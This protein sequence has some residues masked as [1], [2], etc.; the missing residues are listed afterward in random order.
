MRKLVF[1]LLFPLF[2]LGQK[3]ITKTVESAKTFVLR[4]TLKDAPDST[5]VF[6]SRSGEAEIFSTSYTKNGAFTLFGSLPHN[7]IY[8]L[9]VVGNPNVAYLFIGN[10]NITVSGSA[11]SLESLQVV[12]SSSHLDYLVYKSRFNVL[13]NQ[14]NT[15]ARTIN[16]TPNGPQRDSLL[17]QF[18]SG[19]QQV[20]KQVIKFLKEKPA[21]PVTAFLLYVTSPIGGDATA[22]EKRYTLLLP[23]AKKGFYGAEIEKIILASKIGM[24]G[25]QAVDFIQPDVDSKPVSLSSF[26]GKYVLVDFWASW[27]GPCR[28]ENPA[29]VAA[30]NAFKDKN[31]TIY[32]VSLDQAKDNWVKAIKDD[33]LTWAHA[34]D[35]K[36]WQNEAAQLYKI[37]SI[38]AN[39]LIDPKGKIIARNLRGED[40]Y[41]RLEKELK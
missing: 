3:S 10:E 22:L 15:L 21:S 24:E 36:Y 16:Q 11:K 30:Y 41:K 7:D 34:S 13:E 28:R 4:G 25:T 6:L 33:N 12:G 26:R 31:F 37:Y 8:Q 1:L 19:K 29:I 17:E 20:L 38:P 27:C 5:L 14:L 35:L 9:S 23:G 32:G 40:L 18:E 39:M 2:S